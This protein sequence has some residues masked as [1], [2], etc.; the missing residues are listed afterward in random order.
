MIILLFT[1]VVVAV[2]CISG[3]KEEPHNDESERYRRKRGKK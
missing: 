1:V 2:V 3:I